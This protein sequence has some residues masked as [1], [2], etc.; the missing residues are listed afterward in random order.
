M[1]EYYVDGS[2]WNGANSAYCV[3]QGKKKKF[4][5]VLYE[6]K[7]GLE[8][9]YIAL[10]VALADANHNDKIYTDS[11][12]MVN[13]IKFDTKID[14][15]HI[16]YMKDD[17]RSLIES[18]KINIV[19]ISR[20]QNFAGHILEAR[21]EKLKNYKKASTEPKQNF[22]Q[23]SQTGSVK[24]DTNSDFFEER[25][26]EGIRKIVR[27]TPN[28]ETVR[29]CRKSLGIISLGNRGDFDGDL[30]KQLFG[31]IA[32]SIVMEWMGLGLP[33]VKKGFDGGS[34]LIYNGSK[35]D[36]KCEI[37]QVPFKLEYVHNLTA[38]QKNYQTDGYIFV[39]FNQPKNEYEI[40]GFITKEDFFKNARKFESGQRRT[41][42]DGSQMEVKGRGMYELDQ[43][44]LTKFKE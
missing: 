24:K 7:S 21:L 6:E 40:C 20:G 13:Q 42:N 28:I 38:A 12:V 35:W 31:L 3:C 27:I 41:R 37:R 19:W 4:L 32:Q 1:T 36:V 14:G 39:S 25:E 22:S 2:G 34:D 5:K 15:T 33:E 9:E 23:G 43:K 44:Y 10:I 16:S 18:K 29:H 26:S 30:Y 11:Q 8:M 17:A